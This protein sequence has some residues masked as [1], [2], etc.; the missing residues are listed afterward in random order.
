[1]LLSQI[2]DAEGR[3]R[4]VARNGTE[5]YVV[6]GVDSVYRLAAD[7]IRAGERLSRR[8]AQ[9]GFGEA[10]DLAAAYDE[11]RVLPPIMHPD[12]THLHLTGTGLTHL[13]SAAARD[14]MHQKLAEQS[15]AELTDSMKMFRLGLEGGKPAAGRAGVQPEWFYKGNGLSVAAPGAPL[16]APAF[17]EDAG[18]EPEIA[19]VYLVGEDGTPFRVGFALANEFSD[20]VMER[21]NYLYLAH[22]KLRPAAFGPEILLGE[23]PANVEGRS[24]IRRGG[25][26]VWEKPF[27]SGE[28][29]MSHT[30]ANLEHH[31]FKYGLFRH[32]GDVHV[33]MFGTA[34]LS[35]VDGIKVA[36][37]DVFEIEAAPFGL[38]LRNPLQTTAVPDAGAAVAV[39]VL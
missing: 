25:A 39:Q 15:E 31:H 26:V 13:G 23:L 9:L 19:G 21:R 3:E 35:F 18:E 27:L 28:R 32:P 11:G 7:A 16:V 33:H 37:G 8:I 34:T 29:N 14:A 5:A 17:A 1:M 4:V 12:P 10:V 20:H 38:P 30:I 24:R 36:P 22:S 6:K 2:R